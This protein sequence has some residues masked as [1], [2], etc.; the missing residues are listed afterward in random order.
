MTIMFRGISAVNLDPKGRLGIPT[1]YRERLRVEQDGQLIVTIDPESPCLLL[2]PLKQWE[3]IEEQ[4]QQLPSLNSTA[5]QI[6]RLLLGHATDVELDSQGRVLIPA[7]LREHAELDKKTVLV[8]QGKRFEIWAENVW[9][10]H[11]N[12]WLSQGLG[13]KQELVPELTKIAL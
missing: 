3:V 4:L 2:Y 12:M 6:Q 10:Q 13:D 5:R 8:G 9:Q 1:R 11:R 7:L